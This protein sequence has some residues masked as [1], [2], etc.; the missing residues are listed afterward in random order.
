M[1]ALHVLCEGSGSRKNNKMTAIEVAEAAAMTTTKANDPITLS[2]ITILGFVIFFI[3]IGGPIMG[4]YKDFK[5]AR[6]D[7]TKSDAESLLYEQL[8]AQLQQNSNAILKLQEERNEWFKKATL[9]EHEVEK[10]KTFE[11]MVTSMKER[12]AVKDRVIEARDG[13]IR[14][15]TR[16]ILEMKDQ[17]HALELRLSRDEAN[18]CNE[19]ILKKSHMDAP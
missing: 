6:A 13:E 4:L 16:T 12:L 14:S 11:A 8:Q 7:N 3:A 9:L 2:V 19:C 18:F 15:L 5:K 1:L 10:L 17:L